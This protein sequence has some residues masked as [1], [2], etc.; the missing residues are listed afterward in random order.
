MCQGWAVTCNCRDRLALIGC[1]T[2]SKLV[3]HSQA[4][5]LHMGH[6]LWLQFLF[7]FFSFSFPGPSPITTIF[8][9][10]DLFSWAPNL[11]FPRFIGKCLSSQF[12]KPVD[13][14]L[15][16]PSR[17]EWDSPGA[18]GLP[19]LAQFPWGP[20]L[21]AVLCR[22]I[23]ELSLRSVTA[24][25]LHHLSFGEEFCYH[26]TRISWDDSTPTPA[27]QLITSLITVSGL[28]CFLL[29]VFKIFRLLSLWNGLNSTL[30][31]LLK[32]GPW[33]E[34]GSEGQMLSF[35]ISKWY[36][37]PYFQF[38]I[39]KFL[40][41]IGYTL[42]VTEYLV[43]LPGRDRKDVDLIHG[44]HQLLLSYII[45]RMPSRPLRISSS[46]Q[47]KIFQFSLKVF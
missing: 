28:T 23:C 1:G 3:Y 15:F 19:P 35:Y 33:I 44:N 45:P 4:R 9:L 21:K 11:T 46:W 42:C 12:H 7:F 26:G 22:F 29:R 37:G 6:E 2:L 20:H 14:F 34:L 27:P 32:A 25:L 31:L 8:P 24:G 10:L 16:K 30:L 36:F 17:N 38:H 40:S 47:R 41:V 39:C 43:L 18:W 13:S 5:S